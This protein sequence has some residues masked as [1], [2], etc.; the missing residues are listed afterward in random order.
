M[1]RPKGSEKTPGSGR[2][3][4]TTN[5]TTREMREMVYEAFELAG[6]VEYLL[7]H[8]KENPKTFLTL[9]ARL[10][11]QAAEHKIEGDGIPT[12]ILRQNYIEGTTT[13]HTVGDDD[14]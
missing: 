12:L 4:G 1:G 5:K 6:G 7:K 10:I 14:E 8:A 13:E 9:A 2:K 11:P 3:K